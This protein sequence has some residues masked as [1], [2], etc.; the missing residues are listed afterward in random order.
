MHRIHVAKRAGRSRLQPGNAWE[1]ARCH[2]R[3]V[4]VSRCSSPSGTGGAAC[5]ASKSSQNLRKKHECRWQLAIVLEAVQKTLNERRTHHVDA[6]QEWNLP[7]M[8][9]TRRAHAVQRCA[10][11]DPHDEGPASNSSKSTKNSSTGFRKRSS[12]SSSGGGSG[13]SSSGRRRNRSG[14]GG[15]SGGG[16]GGEIA[17][18]TLNAPPST[19][20]CL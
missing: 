4:S 12:S 16:G 1:A 6:T 7:T 15:S 18:G 20:V 14:S 13:N 17:H 2:P 11:P 19:N 5:P 10:N 8:P 3:V 9:K